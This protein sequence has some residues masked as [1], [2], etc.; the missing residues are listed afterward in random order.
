MS[1][2]M[3]WAGLHQV[4]SACSYFCP[5]VSPCRCTKGRTGRRFLDAFHRSRLGKTDRK[6]PNASRLRRSVQFPACLREIWPADPPHHSRRF[7]AG[8]D[9]SPRFASPSSRPGTLPHGESRPQ[10]GPGIRWVLGYFVYFHDK[11]IIRRHQ[12]KDKS[13]FRMIKQGNI[14]KTYFDQR[15]PPAKS[16]P[17]LD[18]K[19]FI[20][21]IEDTYFSFV[22]N[23]WTQIFRFWISPNA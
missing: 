22:S 2:C 19:F 3:T 17:A 4:I 6:L 14:D 16:F 8:C 11:Q 5:T 21:S 23:G 7:S 20:T 12:R 18:P 15:R 9:P 1:L 10:I 13:K